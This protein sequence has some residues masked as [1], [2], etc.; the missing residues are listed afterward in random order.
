M[1]DE[2][3]DAYLIG[4]GYNLERMRAEINALIDELQSTAR[5][6]LVL[7]DAPVVVRP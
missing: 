6:I 4:H 1:T 2:E 5:E 3:T 7:T